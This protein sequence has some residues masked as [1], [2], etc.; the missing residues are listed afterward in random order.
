MLRPASTLSTWTSTQTA[1]AS[2]PSKTRSAQASSRIGRGRSEHPS[3]GLHAY[4]LRWHDQEHRSWQLPGHHV[5]FRGDGGYVIA[6]P[7]RVVVADGSERG[8]DLL[9]VAPHQ[10]R[11]VDGNTLRKFLDPPRRLAPP[12]DIPRV[13]VQTSS[14]TGLRLDPRAIATGACSG[15]RAAWPSPTTRSRQPSGFSARQPKAPDSPIG[16]PRPLSGRRTGS[17]RDLD[18][19][20]L[21]ALPERLRR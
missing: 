21:R 8:Y 6:P 13:P 4:F 7:S 14:P 5:D 19:R 3:G 1:Q 20:T 16:R 11:S 9:A 17:R 18:R 15:Q 10:P 12:S 2:L